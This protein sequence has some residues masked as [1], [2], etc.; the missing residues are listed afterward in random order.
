MS[1]K[2]SLARTFGVPALI[3][4]A[5]LTGLISALMGEGLADWISWIGLGIPVAAIAWAWLSR[6]T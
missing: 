3:A 2:P 6:R 5:S 1:R 4:V